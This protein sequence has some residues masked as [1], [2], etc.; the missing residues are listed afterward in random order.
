MSGETL[1]E[2]VRFRRFLKERRAA[3]EAHLGKF[4]AP[5]PSDEP[6]ILT[7][8]DPVISELVMGY[9]QQ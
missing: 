4:L 7:M 2:Q 8:D 3:M 6:I 5:M 9:L 1:L